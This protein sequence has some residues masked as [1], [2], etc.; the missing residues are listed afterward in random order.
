MKKITIFFV[1]T[2]VI[3]ILVFGFSSN[4]AGPTFKSDRTIIKFNIAPQIVK[5]PVLDH[6]LSGIMESFESSTFPPA[7][8]IK[9]T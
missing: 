1:S 9:V 3:S 5:G 8:W 4:N 2:I 6:P 7:G